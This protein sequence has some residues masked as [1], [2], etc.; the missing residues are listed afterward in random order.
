MSRPSSNAFWPD[1]EPSHANRMRLYMRPSRG[2]RGVAQIFLTAEI[3]Q[4][5]IR[6]LVSFR[7][8]A[9]NLSTSKTEIP[10]LRLGMTEAHLILLCVLCALRGKDRFFLNLRQV[11]QFA[12]CH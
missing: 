9:R 12:Q 10:R 3:A 11:A 5:E 1:S 7:A 4:R 6:S 8:K 2:Q